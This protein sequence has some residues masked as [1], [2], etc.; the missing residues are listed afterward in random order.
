MGERHKTLVKTK[1]FA[2][3]VC[4][5]KR[6]DFIVVRL[7]SGTGHTTVHHHLQ[8]KEAMRL[9]HGILRAVEFTPR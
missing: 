8:P 2:V 7:W 4:T 9:A 6:D 5:A 3:E 1:K